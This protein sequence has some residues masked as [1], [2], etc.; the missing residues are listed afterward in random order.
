MAEFMMRE[1]A[2]D[3]ELEIASRATSGWEHGN[4]I[5]HGTQKILKKYKIAYNSSKY[6]Q[7]ISLE[8]FAYFDYIIGMD[9]TNVDDLKQLSMGQFNQKIF[10]FNDDGVPDPYYTGDFEETYTLVKKGCQNWL[11]KIN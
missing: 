4:P 10:L 3:K 8:D 1:L 2:S 11:E 6:S 7:Q 5:H 9:K